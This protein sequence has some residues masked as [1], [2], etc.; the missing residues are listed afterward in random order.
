[1]GFNFFE[2]GLYALKPEN[3]KSPH[4]KFL[5]DFLEK[6]LQIQILDSSRSRKLLP[7][8]RCVYS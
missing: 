3:L 5:K 1:M 2:P 4:F 6:K 7:F 8:S